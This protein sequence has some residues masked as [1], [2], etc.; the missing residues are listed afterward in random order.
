LL[1]DGTPVAEHPL[2]QR[3]FAA[4]GEGQG[5]HRMLGAPDRRMTKTPEEAG[6]DI[7]RKMADP[8]FQKAMTD[9]QHPEHAA[10]M[11]EWQALHQAKAV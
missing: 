1:A 6:R 3:I 5:E 9:S 8:A 4:V 11:A 2:I 7:A 10:A